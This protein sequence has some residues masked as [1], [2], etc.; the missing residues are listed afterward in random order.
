MGDWADIMIVEDE[1]RLRGFALEILEMEGISAVGAADG[2]EAI[3]YFA[4]VLEQGGQMPSILL[5]DLT[6]PCMNGYEVYAQI[7]TTPWID[8]VTVIITSA[9]GD[10]FD[11]LPGPA[12]TL[13]LT[14]PYDVNSL[15]S[16]L[17]RV[18]PNLFAPKK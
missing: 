8:K 5:M 13:L 3:A 18:G 7:A 16:T 15:I 14:K 17:R 11:P 2:C 4:R 12:D 6:M 10:E 1:R 9:V